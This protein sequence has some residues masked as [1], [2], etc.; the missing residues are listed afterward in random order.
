M[1]YEK[2]LVSVNGYRMAYVDTGGDADP[3]VFLHGNVTSSYMWRNIIPHLE[4]HARCI[5]PDQPLSGRTPETD[6]AAGPRA[7]FR[8]NARYPV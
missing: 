1:R 4:P 2:R 3:V 5:A 7:R 8:L 6:R